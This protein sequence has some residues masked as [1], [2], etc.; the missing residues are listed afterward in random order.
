PH[1]ARAID[2]CINNV[3]MWKEL[4]RQL[5]W[6]CRFSS[7]YPQ[8]ALW[9]QPASQAYSHVCPLFFAIGFYLCSNQ[10]YPH[11]PDKA[12]SIRCCSILAQFGEPPLRNDAQSY[13]G[14]GS[15]LPSSN[16]PIP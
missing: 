13:S 7:S 6:L 11:H 4:C 2:D 3:L 9:A 10:N 14:C 15:P 8:L 12:E 16:H 1:M 5:R